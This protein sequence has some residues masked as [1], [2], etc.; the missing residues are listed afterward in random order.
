MSISLI[1]SGVQSVI[2][3]L[4]MNLYVFHE[5]KSRRNIILISTILGAILTVIPV[6]MIYFG[7]IKIYLYGLFLG[8]IIG[9]ISGY[10]LL[11]VRDLSLWMVK[12]L[13][14]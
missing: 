6:A 10:L 13:D 2:Y 3:T 4:I 1:F 8:C 12:K 7:N 9:A 5:V 11:K 14:S